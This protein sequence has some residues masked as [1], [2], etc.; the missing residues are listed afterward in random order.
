MSA[1]VL[2]SSLR[3]PAFSTAMRNLASEVKTASES[4]RI[5]LF[6][7]VAP[8]LRLGSTE[9]ERVA[10]DWGHALQIPP[11]LLEEAVGAPA[12]GTLSRWFASSLKLLSREKEPLRRA[13][14]FAE[15]FD[16][17]ELRNCVQSLESGIPEFDESSLQP[18]LHAAATRA[19]AEA[20]RSL[21]SESELDGQLELAE[22]FLRTIEAL[23][24][25]IRLR[26]QSVAARLRLQ[27]QMFEEDRNALI[28]DALDAYELAMRDH[29]EERSNWDES[30]LWEQFADR[31]GSA[32]ILKKFQPLQERTP[33]LRQHR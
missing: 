33:R 23:V 12:A 18:K 27:S 28:E 11:L 26:L 17:D 2:R 32:Q 25:Q 1:L 31:G 10:Q 20:T 4:D 29:M 30:S 22:R 15:A 5:A 13:R 19:L 16:D 24:E 21:K 6:N 3:A 7:S 14:A 9:R 8:L